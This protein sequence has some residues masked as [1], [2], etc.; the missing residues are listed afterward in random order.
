MSQ[1]ENYTQS[2]TEFEEYDQS[3]TLSEMYDVIQVMVGLVRQ[4]A[5]ETMCGPDANK[6]LK[7]AM[8]RSNQAHINK[9]QGY[10]KLRGWAVVHDATL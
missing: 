6:V 5:R 4:Q 10:A 7:D 2:K 8:L 3:H 1:Y 9:L